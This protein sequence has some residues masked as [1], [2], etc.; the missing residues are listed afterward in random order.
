MNKQPRYR[1]LGRVSKSFDPVINYRC[2]SRFSSTMKLT[3]KPRELTFRRP[4]FL[5]GY[6]KNTIFP[7]TKAGLLHSHALQRQT[8]SFIFDFSPVKAREKLSSRLCEKLRGR[9]ISILAKRTCRFKPY[10]ANISAGRLT[11]SLR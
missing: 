4:C 3:S 11:D 8:T 10:N 7:G 5:S 1:T 9:Q 2:I 6:K